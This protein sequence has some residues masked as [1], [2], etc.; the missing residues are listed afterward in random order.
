M[1]SPLVSVVMPCLNEEKAIGVCIQ[2]IQQAFESN[3]INGEIIVCD[4]GSTDASANIAKQMGVKV[5]YEQQKGYGRAYIKGFQS[6]QGK[7]LIMGDADDTY[8]FSLI[9]LFLSKLRDEKYDFV[10]GSR[11]YK[12]F[13]RKSSPVLHQLIGNPTITF[14]LNALFGTHYTDVYCGFRGF[15]RSAYNIIR[16]VSP[17][18]EFNLELAI[19]AGLANLKIT[20]VPIVLYPRIGDSKLRTFRDGWRS[21]R[22]MLL[23]CPNKVFIG[24]GFFLLFVG[25]LMHFI[26]ILNYGIDNIL[27]TFILGFLANV[28][29]IIGFQIVSL[30]LHAKSYSWSRRFEQDNKMLKTFYQHFNLESGLL[31]GMCLIMIGL[32]I[33]IYQLFFQG[34][35]LQLD[36]SMVAY[37]SLAAT[38]IFVGSGTIFSSLFISAMS[39]RRSGEN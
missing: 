10:T 37:L 22:M 12:K 35:L 5:V 26:S 16:P 28:S 6:A 14:I 7:Y 38:L 31:A 3:D 4:N 25:F 39:I 24:P 1:K 27:S 2:K 9:P 18:M 15:S 13:S 8:D 19:N 30:G 23:Y 29:S 34:R 17:G 36:S 11:N 33:S 20:E 21:L 32:V